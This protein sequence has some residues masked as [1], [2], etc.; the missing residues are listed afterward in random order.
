MEQLGGDGGKALCRVP[1]SHHGREGLGELGV[2]VPALPLWGLGVPSPSLGSSGALPP[3]ET[4]EVVSNGMGT[5][6]SFTNHG[7]DSAITN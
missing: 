1:R 5:A 7:A 4:T 6:W 3:A 2:A